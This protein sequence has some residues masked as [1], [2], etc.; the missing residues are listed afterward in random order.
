MTWF[1][2]LR[3]G[4]KLLFAFL[5]L[6]ILLGGVLGGLGYYNLQNV[7]NVLREITDQRV[8]SVQNST[9]VE[10]YALRT[11]LDEKKYL[12]SAN[13]TR[14]DK[15][16]FQKSAMTNIDE[17]IK[18]L[19][20]VDAVATQYK[21]QD[22]LA[23]SKEV[24]TVTLQYKDLYNQGVAKLDENAGLVTTMVEN[25]TTVTDLAKA[26]FN[27]K[28]G[29][30][31]EVSL[32]QI[33]I[34]V[35]IWDTAL[36]TRL[37]QNKYILYHDAKYF[38]ALE[39]GIKKLDTRYADLKKITS[40]SADLQKIDEAQK[41]T[42]NYY[43]A[44][45]SWVKTDNELTSILAEMNTI[46]LKVQE[47][48][49]AAEDSGW[50]ATTATKEKSAQ[51]VSS[52]LTIT[53]V[54][55]GLAILLGLLLGIFIS[56]SI[57]GPLGI[58]VNA[59]RAL[60]VGDMA[61]DLSEKEKDKARLRKD[62]IGDIGKALDQLINYMQGMGA[63]ATSIANNDLSVSITPKS[64]KDELGNAF[65]RMIVGLRKVI[66]QVSDSANSVASAAS[67][68]AKASEQSGEAT[69]QIAITI[70]QV[71]K[72]TAEQTEGVTKTAGSMEQM[73]RAIDG[74]AKGAQEQATAVTQASQVA[75]RISQSIEQ[76]ATNAQA[77]T[78]DSAEAARYS[79]DGA[80][81]VRETINGMEA[82]RS[83]VGLS[84]RKVEEMGTRSEEI[85]AIVETI[86]DIASQTNLLALNAAIEAARA[87]E[88]GKG[89]AVV[90]DEVRKL[91]ERSSLA[92]KEI[93]GLIKGIQ[94][95]VS[96]AVSAMKESAGEVETGVAKANSAGEV[97]NNILEAAESVFKQAEE[98]GQ[99][100]AKVRTAASELVNAVDS[101]SS[102]I[103]E[104]TAAT[105]EM[106]AN[107]TELTQAIENIASVS[108]Q[109]SAA[110]EEVSASTEEVSAQVEEVSASASTMKDLADELLQ[111]VQRFK[112]K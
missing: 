99:A 102:V 14:V 83:K 89:F 46:G 73:S 48:A 9:A 4:T 13:D 36:Q 27:E 59:A 38:T 57:T 29:K 45:Q 94:K 21:D 107:S 39:E 54:A 79:R 10:R 95:T 20:A 91:A 52:A 26:F 75:S 18:A 53:M 93:A 47:N 8:P 32:A 78:R 74:V 58:A 87:G 76:V 106:A 17:I 61:R 84:A 56:R 23:K 86:E 25:G 41:A 34:L 104:N 80:K 1:N 28:T 111:I 65:A 16:A 105:E 37:N 31:D 109:N 64:E 69:N 67:Q 43:A 97:L 40:V 22:L 11:I 19:D 85:G 90:A 66:G 82:I 15:A 108:E 7:N 35:D 44:A 70:Q 101:V 24:R 92:T 110:V 33:P 60:S 96:E 81:T 63:A 98:A 68:L 77:V 72:G 62:E 42:A 5:G 2:N 49:M 103:E 12:L 6:V 3:M 100:A 88:Q 55:V 71:A 50:V 51:V 112:L 30:T